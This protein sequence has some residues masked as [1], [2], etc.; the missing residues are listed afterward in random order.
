VHNANPDLARDLSRNRAHVNLLLSQF[1]EAEA[2]AKASLIGR[3]DDQRSKELDSKALFRAG[4]AAYNLGKYREAKE[5]FERRLKLTPDISSKET[6]A[7]LR[8][9]DLRLREQEAGTHDLSKIRAGLSRARPRADAASFVANTTIKDSPGRGR[10]LFATRDIPEGDIIFIE[11]AFCVVWGFESDVLTAITYD[12]RDDRIRVSPVG[13]TRAV[14]HKLLNNP[15]QTAAVMNLY[16]D[17]PGVPTTNTATNTTT[18]DDGPAIDTFRVHDIVSRNAFGPGSQFGDAEGARNAS[19]GLW[20]RAALGNHSCAANARKEFVGDLMVLRAA[21]RIARGDEIFH[22]YDESGDYDA[23]REALA[24][25]W[26]FDCACELCVV[27][28]EDPPAVRRRRR[29]LI[30]EVDAFVARERPAGA[31]RRAVVR[32]QRLAKAIEETYDAQRYKGLPRLAAR[33]I[34]EWLAI[35]TPRR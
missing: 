15:S 18:A 34:Q 10:G 23:R 35:A 25:T 11:K 20:L 8:K 9:I 27:E 21:R 5:L 12:V 1:D 3:D 19:T 29:E 17:W 4:T 2:D 26:G 13:L 6:S 16:G 33:T 24:R 31:N 14:V 22:A 7:I 32:A 28:R 30:A